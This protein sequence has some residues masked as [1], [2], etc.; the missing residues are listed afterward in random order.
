MET[1]NELITTNN[2]NI[3]LQHCELLEKVVDLHV[4]RVFEETG[5]VAKDADFTAALGE[6]SQSCQV[7]HQRTRQDRIATLPDKLQDHFCAEET[8][9][10]NV[11]PGCF[12]VVKRLNVFD[13]DVCLRLGADGLVNEPILGCTVPELFLRGA[14]HA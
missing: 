4:H 8:L 13:G 5:E 3:L 11:V 6:E 7:D 9:K 2:S 14:Q 10:A 1:N 12:P